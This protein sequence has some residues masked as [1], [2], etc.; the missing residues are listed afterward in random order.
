MSKA[1]STLSVPRTQVVQRT[2]KVIDAR[3]CV[4]SGCRF[5][6]HDFT[7]AHGQ[8]IRSCGAAVWKAHLPTSGLAEEV[9][10]NPVQIPGHDAERNPYLLRLLMSPD[11]VR[12]ECGVTTLTHE[13]RVL[14]V[15]EEET[16]SELFRS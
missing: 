12:P 11:C 5:L 13:E 15:D 1:S 2:E 9:R 10:R 14:V 4:L 16:E 3:I 8:E 7:D 6:V